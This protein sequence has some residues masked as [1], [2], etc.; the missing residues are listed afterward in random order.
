MLVALRPWVVHHDRSPRL[1]ARKH[2]EETGKHWWEQ[3]VQ[4]QHRE[5]REAALVI[6]ERR[7]GLESQESS[8]EQHQHQQSNRHCERDTEPCG[9]APVTDALEAEVRDRSGAGCWDCLLYTS[10]AAD[11]EDS[12]DLGG[13][14]IIKKKKKEKKKGDIML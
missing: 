8:A 14:R 5:H 7:P 4:R 13:R 6:P 9:V 12:V 10:D 2:T 1:V 11:E 3:E